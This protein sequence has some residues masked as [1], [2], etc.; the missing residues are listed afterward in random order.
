MIISVC[1]ALSAVPSAWTVASGAED[2]CVVAPTLLAIGLTRVYYTS[3]FVLF[4]AVCLTVVV[5][6]AR[7]LATVRTWPMCLT[8]Q[9]AR[10]KPSG[11][12]TT[13]RARGKARRN[14]VGVEA[15]DTDDVWE[16]GG[17]SSAGTGGNRDRD[18][19]RVPSEREIES[20]S[21]LARQLCNPTMKWAG[22][23]CLLDLKHPRPSLVGVTPKDELF[24]RTLVPRAP[25]IGSDVIVGVQW[26]NVMRDPDRETSRDQPVACAATGKE[27]A[28]LADVAGHH[29]GNDQRNENLSFASESLNEIS[30]ESHTTKELT[31]DNSLSHDTSFSHSHLAEQEMTTSEN[32]AENPNDKADVKHSGKAAV[33]GERAQSTGS[34]LPHPDQ[35]KKSSDLQMNGKAGAAALDTVENLSLGEEKDHDERAVRETQSRGSMGEA[36]CSRQGPQTDAA[37]SE[38]RASRTSRT[39]AVIFTT[40]HHLSAELG[41]R[42]V[43]M[44]GES[45]AQRI[46]G[47]G[48]EGKTATNVAGKSST[49]RAARAFRLTVLLFVVTVVFVVSRVPPYMAV[50]WLLYARDAA[51]LAPSQLALQTYASTGYVLNHFATPLLFLAFSPAF[52]EAAVALWTRLCSRGS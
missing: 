3:R 36:G 49:A 8:M 50:V 33:V 51:P 26:T 22:D 17:P 27:T 7:A 2:Q 40:T 37:D 4:L 9:G 19:G 47:S 35:R 31:D 14:R 23:Y 28:V 41:P 6:Y 39:A 24:P 12:R 25:T 34:L 52:R 20:L 11:D 30:T 44:E 18:R 42:D 13:V 1:C 32:A 5:C 16:E 43:S 46:S 48:N 38:H 15:S 45:E 29:D 21:S 10:A